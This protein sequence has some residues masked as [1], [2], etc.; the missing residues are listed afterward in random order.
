MDYNP[1][2]DEELWALDNE[3]L[4]FNATGKWA[5]AELR[6]LRESSTVQGEEVRALRAR[7]QELESMNERLQPPALM[8]YINELANRLHEVEETLRLREVHRD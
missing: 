8:N 1:L 4:Q 2:S 5:A 3:Q 7:V 6:A